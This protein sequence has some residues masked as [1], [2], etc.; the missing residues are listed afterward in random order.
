MYEVK[1]D[2]G[3]GQIYMSNI[4]YLKRFFIYLYILMFDVAYE[5]FA[6]SDEWGKT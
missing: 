5:V 1:K 3:E 6:F 4:S 2:Q